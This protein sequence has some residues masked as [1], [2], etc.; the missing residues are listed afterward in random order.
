[1]KGAST[2]RDTVAAPL[3]SRR[4]ALGEM[5]YA[6]IDIHKSVL[7][8]ALLDPASGEMSDARMPATREALRGL[9]LDPLPL[10]P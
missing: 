10:T 8:A 9:G 3:P 1:L 5:L 2:G 6:A 7:Q 4:E